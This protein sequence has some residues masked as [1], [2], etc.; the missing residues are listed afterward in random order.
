[1]YISESH[2]FAEFFINKKFET[3]FDWVAE[4]LVIEI[5]ILLFSKGDELVP[6]IVELKDVNFTSV[7]VDKYWFNMQFMMVLITSDIKDQHIKD[8]L[9][10]I[11]I[12]KNPLAQVDDS[13]KNMNLVLEWDLLLSRGNGFAIHGFNYNRYHQVDYVI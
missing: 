3:S 2:R 1:M 11:S 8:Q 13:C 9:W 6:R 5:V 7:R 4:L 10:L 12:K